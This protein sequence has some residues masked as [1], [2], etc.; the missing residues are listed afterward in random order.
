MVAGAVLNDGRSAS[1][2]SGHVNVAA[3]EKAVADAFDTWSQER[4]ASLVD[5]NKSLKRMDWYKEMQDGDAYLDAAEEGTNDASTA[6]T[7]SA[8][9][10]LITFAEIGSILKNGNRSGRLCMA[11]E[12]CL[13]AIASALKLIAASRFILTLTFISS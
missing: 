4:A 5:S 2:V 12:R 6:R 8:R 3:H 7:I 9:H 11:A 1:V 13:T 10:G